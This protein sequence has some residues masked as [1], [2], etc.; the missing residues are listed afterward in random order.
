MVNRLSIAALVTAM[1][2]FAVPA[3]MARTFLTFEE[4]LQH[5]RDLQRLHKDRTTLAKSELYRAYGTFWNPFEAK[6]FNSGLA[7]AGGNHTGTA[8]DNKGC[9]VIV[10]YDALDYRNGQKNDAGG[11]KD[12]NT[13]IKPLGVAPVCA[14][15]F[16]AEPKGYPG[17][18]EGE[19]LGRDSWSFSNYNKEATYD[20]YLVL[21]YVLCIAQ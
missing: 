10:Y 8:D 7:L 21:K 15:K 18:G 4:F 9:A 14:H 1:I 13:W 19:E 17:R 6:G 11:K 16:G 2:T 3:V 5:E 20:T 12:F